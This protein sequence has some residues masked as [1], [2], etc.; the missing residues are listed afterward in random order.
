MLSILKNTSTVY[1]VDS[2]VPGG[3]WKSMDCGASWQNLSPSAV[4][5]VTPTVYALAVS[6]KNPGTLYAGTSLGVIT[7]TD[8]GE[9]WLSLASDIGLIRFLVIDPKHENTLYASGSG[10]LFRI[11]PP[12]V[13]AI[14]F[15]V[16]VVTAGASYT[17]TIAGL[18]LSDET[19]FDLQVHAPGSV[20]DIVV[21]NWQTGTSASHSLPAGSDI[22]TWTVDGVRA[23]Q[24]PENHTDNFASVEATLIVSP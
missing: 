23:H 7:S 1:A 19:C 18:N 5:A 15:D 20:A 13:T 2:S 24:D 16:T 8:G 22:G 21:L 9:S 14:A 11:G 10:G 3:L 17:T 4:D 6:P 12:T